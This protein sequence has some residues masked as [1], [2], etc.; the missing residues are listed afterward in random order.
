MDE[1]VLTTDVKRRRN[2]DLI[3]I[4]VLFV[5]VSAV[6]AFLMYKKAD[7][8]TFLLTELLIAAALGWTFYRSARQ[9]AVTLHFKGDSLT[10]TYGD[11][12]KYDVR[13]VDRSYFKLIQTK[14]EEK[15]DIGTLKVESTNFRVMY[16]SEFSKLR[17]Y[18]DSHFES[19]KK[20]V[21]YLDDED[22]E[23]S[24]D[25][26][27]CKGTDAQGCENSE[28][29]ESA[30]GNGGE[31]TGSGQCDSIVGEGAGGKADD[32]KAGSGKE[33]TDGE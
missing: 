16:I 13:D 2:G 23:D 11:G 27:D 19:K 29:G 8:K 28:G 32:G 12:R 26:E 1:L 31:D 33:D 4:A 22:S 24:E 5:I 9:G 14:R 15:A 21:C 30:D 3:S 6:A 7:I 10:I 18:M 17:S 20:S 25:P